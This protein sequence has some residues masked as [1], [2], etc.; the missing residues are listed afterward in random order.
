LSEIFIGIRDARAEARTRELKPALDTRNSIEAN[1]KWYQEFV[2]QVSHLR[3]QQPVGIGLLYQLN[4]DYPFGVD[5]SFYISDMKLLPTGAVEMKGYAR[6][7]DAV[8]A[9]LKSL[10]FAG[11]PESGSRM[12]GNLAYEVQEGAPQPVAATGQGP[13]PTMSGGLIAANQ[14][15]P[16]VI[17]WSIKGTYLPME[18]FAPPPPTKPGTK[19]AQAPAPGATP[20]PAGQ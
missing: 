6:N 13:L 18:E 5:Q 1:L 10:E 19:P 20:K 12:F 16:G 9:F 11:G 4:S 15:R 3:R 17:V 2:K 8:A 14:L 7:K